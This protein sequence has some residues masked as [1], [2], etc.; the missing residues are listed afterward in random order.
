MKR[1]P[2]KRWRSQDIWATAKG[3]RGKAMAT[4]VPKR[5]VCVCSAMIIS[6]RNG[7]WPASG[8]T[9]ES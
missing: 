6:G 7:S 8:V 4:A 2:E 3:L 9:T 1:P 5:S